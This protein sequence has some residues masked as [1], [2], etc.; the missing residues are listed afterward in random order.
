[1]TILQ[2]HH[3]SRTHGTG[4]TQVSALQDASVTVECGELLAVMGPSGSGKSTLLNLAGGI[5]A[6][7]SGDVLIDGE[8]LAAQSKQGLARIRRKNIGYIFQDLNLIR[9]LNVLENVALPLEL[10]GLSTKK[11]RAQAAHCLEEVGID[12]FMYDFPDNLSGG[13]QQRI[14]IARAVVG[15]RRLLLA[16]EPTG[17]LDSHTGEDILR[18]IRMRC[19]E[20]AAGLLVTHDARNTGWADR[21]IFLRDGRIVDGTEPLN[22]PDCLLRG[23][24]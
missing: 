12:A 22:T 4:P 23:T 16:D 20:G 1:M 21:T 14:A 5:D 3:V 19:D 10:D 6:P 7:T 13:Q 18:L 8:S 17:A 15:P 11:A 2:L 9:S 24:T